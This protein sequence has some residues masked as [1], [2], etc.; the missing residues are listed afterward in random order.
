MDGIM[1][2][3]GLNSKLKESQIGEAARVKKDNTTYTEKAPDN[4]V[5]S[6]KKDTFTSSGKTGEIDLNTGDKFEK[7][8][9]K[10]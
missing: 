8:P 1:T 5:R 9:Q 6:P 10:K 3:L 4:L 7:T 2:M